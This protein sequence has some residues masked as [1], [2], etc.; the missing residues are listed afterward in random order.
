MDWRLSEP[1]HQISR[2]RHGAGD[3]F[4]ICGFSRP[5]CNLAWPGIRKLAPLLCL[6]AIH[7][8]LNLATYPSMPVPLA[9]NRVKV[10]GIGDARRRRV[11]FG[12]ALFLARCSAG[13]YTASPAPARSRLT[14]RRFVFTPL[15]VAAVLH[16]PYR[17][18]YRRVVPIIVATLSTI[19]CAGWLVS[20]WD[21][22]NP[23]GFGDGRSGGLLAVSAI[24]CLLLPPDERAALK[25]S[26]RR[27]LINRKM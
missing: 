5:L 1:R 19:A 3:R 4:L 20:T 8:S 10:P 16:Q 15:Y 14:L 27:R 11:Q 22:F 12:L 6:M 21:H 24:T 17:T 25:K 13:D 9:A 18:Y 23:D 7:Q 26:S 2:H